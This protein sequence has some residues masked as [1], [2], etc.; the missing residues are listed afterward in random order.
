MWLHVLVAAV[1]GGLA[2]S[3]AKLTVKNRAGGV[4]AQRIIFGLAFVLL[5]AAFQRT[6]VP[7]AQGMLASLTIE[8]EFA[9]NPA[10]SALRKY[11][12]LTFDSVIEAAGQSLQHGAT[13]A[14]VMSEVGARIKI[15][16]L[17]KVS[18][19]SDQAAIQYVRVVVASAGELE[20]QGGDLCY[21]F[22][23]PKDNAPAEAFTQLA[24][25]TRGATY[26]ALA[27]V[28]RTSAI[29][30]QAA[31]RQIDVR[32]PL[33]YIASL[34]NNRFGADV[35]MLENPGA[36]EVDKTKVCA[37]AIY[38]YNEIFKLPESAQGKLLRFMLNT[39]GP[40]T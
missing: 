33:T 16:V 24:V 5:W 8:D 11:D 29:S 39:G 7:R 15:S 14:Q 19:A 34:V 12:R 2:A 35:S 22:L 28:I 26:A 36:S 25:T 18:S 30:P 32:E 38:M 13:N 3:L 31:P 1:C 20:R 23:F 9:Q 4:V 27:E 21:Q 6:V 40:Q 10:F 17:P 37:M